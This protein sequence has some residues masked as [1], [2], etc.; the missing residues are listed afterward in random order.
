MT[1]N[2]RVRRMGAVGTGYAV[3]I[4]LSGSVLCAAFE[5][6]RCLRLG[7]K[8]HYSFTHYKG[9]H[10]YDSHPAGHPT[11]LSRKKSVIKVDKVYTLEASIGSQQGAVRE[12]TLRQPFL[13]PHEELNL[14]IL[15]N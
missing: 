5:F 14:K 13:C 6:K 2:T 15:Y 9:V 12:V 7:Y 10:V 1:H 11:A 3:M 8:Q 4:M